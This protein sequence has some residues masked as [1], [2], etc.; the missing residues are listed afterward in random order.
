MRCLW[1][2]LLVLASGCDAIDLELFQHKPLS[3]FEAEPPGDICEHGGRRVLTGLDTNSDGVLDDTEVRTTDYDCNRALPEVLV[4]TRTLLPGTTCPLGGELVEAGLD[5]NGDGELEAEEVSQSAITCRESSTVVYRVSDV[6]SYPLACDEGT[7]LVEA[8]PDLDADG[9]LDDSERRAQTAVCA[10]ASTVRVRLQIEPPGARCAS[11]GTRLNVG[12]DANGNGTLEDSEVATR[13]YVCL[14]T[15][16]FTGDYFLRDA[17]DLEVL[18]AFSRIEGTLNIQDTALPEIVLPSL[19]AVEGPLFVGGNTAL[20]R[21]ELEGLSFVGGG[22]SLYTNPELVTLTLGGPTEQDILWVEGDFELQQNPKLASLDGMKSVQPRGNLSLFDNDS[23][24]DPGSWHLT[25]LP[26]SLDV[27]GNEQLT[28]LPFRALLRVGGSIAINENPALVGLELT[29][30]ETVGNTVTI[31]RNGS[32]TDLTGLPVLRTIQ[33]GLYVTDNDSLVS[34][35]GLGELTTVSWLHVADNDVLAACDFPRLMTIPGRFDL[36]R[37]KALARLGRFPS[38]VYL[39][40][41]TLAQNDSLNDPSGL[42]RLSSMEELEV[43]GNA[44]LRNMDGL[45]HLRTLAKLKVDSNPALERL[46]LDG[47]QRVN[48]TLEIIGNP[49]LPTCMANLFANRVFNGITRTIEGNDDTPTCAPPPDGLTG[50]DASP[51]EG[52]LR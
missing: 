31:H 22:V 5:V 40:R 20:T 19:V 32:L 2:T 24:T 27:I 48:E 12:T 36:M 46:S 7:S 10:P 50:L 47:L 29:R 9:A 15:N 38:L 41:L 3:R 30:L 21:L 25:Q 18:R 34:T 39:P 6:D 43:T 8:G 1:M 52:R 45:N 13:T 28:R 42:D 33:E 37:N 23:L 16:T 51:V 44:S 49:A 4:V 17:V 14:S 26:G 35:A 11:G